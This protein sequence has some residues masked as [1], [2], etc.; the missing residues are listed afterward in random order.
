VF[1]FLITLLFIGGYLIIHYKNRKNRVSYI[2]LAIVSSFA[3]F[4]FVTRMHERYLVATSVICLLAIVV[5]PMVHNVIIAMAV[6][7]C[8]VINMG[9]VMYVY[10]PNAFNPK[11]TTGCLVGSV[12]FI[13]FLVFIGIRT[14]FSTAKGKLFAEDRMKQ[15]EE[16]D[17]NENELKEKSVF[18]M[19]ITEKATKWTKYD[20]IAL[21]IIMAVYS[22]FAL[23][24]IG[25]RYAPSTFWECNSDQNNQILVDMG[26]EVDIDTINYY[27]GYYDN[28]KFNVEYAVHE[29]GPWTSMPELTMV[30]VFCWGDNKNSGVSQPIHARYVRLTNTDNSATVMELVFKDAEGNILTPVNTSDYPELFDE[31][32]MCPK[33][34]TFRDSTYF[35]EIYHARTAYEFLHDLNTYEWTHPPLGK[36]F[37]SIGVYLFGMNP[38]GWR[39]IGILF[40]IFMLPVLY[41]FALRF[42]KKTSFACITTILFAFD[43]MHFAQTR[44]ATIDTY[45]TFFVICMYYY[46]YK[47]YKMSFYDTELK[48]TFIPLGLCGITMGLGMA[49]KWTG[50]YAGGG[51]AVI[52]FITIY[53]RTTEYVYAKKEPT[54]TTDGISHKSI[55]EKFPKN[56][57][58]TLLFCVVFFVIIP[59]TIYAL[60]YIPVKYFRNGFLDECIRQQKMILDYHNGVSDPHPFASKWWQW[61]I[62]YRPIWYYSGTISDTVKEGI[63]SFGNP[64]VWWAG[65]PAFFFLVYR[66][67]Q[68]K[69]KKAMFLVIG[70]LSQYLPWVLVG[71][72]VFFY[73]YFTS[74]PFVVMMVAYS[75]YVLVKE[76]KLKMPVVFAYVTLAVVLFVMFYPVLSGQPVNTSYVDHFLRW[77]DSWVLV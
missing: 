53:R 63:S 75:L 49:S 64:A 74:V 46:M 6:S 47:Y 10:D 77:F 15:I 54:G 12:L 48:K 11:E 61:P 68:K 62:I 4:M 25:N 60:S 51:L 69:D 31:Q 42:F 71:R 32:E 55:I 24:D 43:F 19:Q 18:R 28:R 33:R 37:I 20:F 72:T 1:G 34:S 45:V 2:Y 9:F 40:G 57:I 13:C 35:D 16:K 29:Q 8:S 52:F 50:I 27:L 66:T 5:E 22:A 44:I 58:R 70:Y 73:H 26:Q 36:I 67:V 41:A 7:V 3:S 65:I 76:Y 38:F 56:T 17:V 23:R 59:A 30:S 39:I 21:F 14:Y